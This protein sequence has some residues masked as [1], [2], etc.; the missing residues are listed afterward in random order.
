MSLFQVLHVRENTT[1]I[2]DSPPTYNFNFLN[3][4][5]SGSAQICNTSTG[6]T[7]PFPSNKAAAVFLSLSLHMFYTKGQIK[8]GISPS[9]KQK[10]KNTNKNCF[11]WVTK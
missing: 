8:F 4:P 11:D 9:K 7:V 5:M 6:T 10:K 3:V 2:I 1:A